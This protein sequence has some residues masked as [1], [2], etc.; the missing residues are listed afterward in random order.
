MASPDR[1]TDTYRAALR[2]RFDMAGL[3]RTD[4][5]EALQT[6][7]EAMHPPISG[8]SIDFSSAV[9]RLKASGGGIGEGWDLIG[10]SDDQLR[11]LNASAP[12]S[13]LDPQTRPQE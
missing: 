9:A 10:M 8:V 7:F 4:V 13:S 5:P 6:D 1:E 2:A 11:D 12:Q 3:R